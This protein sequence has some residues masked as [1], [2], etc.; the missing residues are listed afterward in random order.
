MFRRG[1]LKAKTQI[2]GTMK[3]RHKNEEGMKE[4]NIEK[5]VEGFIV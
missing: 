5:K 4:T 2:L 3:G 1:A